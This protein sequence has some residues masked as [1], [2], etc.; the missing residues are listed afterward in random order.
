MSWRSLQGGWLQR[1]VSRRMS[2]TGSLQSVIT[3]TQWSAAAVLAGKQWVRQAQATGTAQNRR[4]A[5]H[6]RKQIG[7]HYVLHTCSH[8]H[9]L[10]LHLTIIVETHC[11]QKR[12][13]K[14]SWLTYACTNTCMRNCAC[15]G[16]ESL[17]LEGQSLDSGGGSYTASA[18]T[19]WVNTCDLH[20]LTGKLHVLAEKLKAELHSICPVMNMSYI[21]HIN[22]WAKIML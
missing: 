16:Q 11:V 21:L 6:L 15:S 14:T 7:Q 4:A 19:S 12:Q 13:R 22:L 9:S 10:V 1:V 8:R 3:G 2:T 17:N 5:Q 18:H 20:T